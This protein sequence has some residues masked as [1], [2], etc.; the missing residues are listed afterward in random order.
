MTH[1]NDL[2]KMVHENAVAHGWWETLHLPD[3]LVMLHAEVSEAVEAFREQDTHTLAD[4]LYDERG[5]PIGF[6]TEL[7]DTVIRAMDIAGQLG[8]DLDLVISTKHAY[9]ITRPYRHGNKRL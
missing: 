1:I 4:I 6:A 2:V 3:K 7:A 5:K 9:N 8:I